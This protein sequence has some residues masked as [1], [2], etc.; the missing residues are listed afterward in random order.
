MPHFLSL[1]PPA[2]TL[3]S[4]LRSPSTALSLAARSLIASPS[5]LHS[6]FS[7]A[8]YASLASTHRSC[9]SLTFPAIGPAALE[10]SEY[11]FGRADAGVE[12]SSRVPSGAGASRGGTNT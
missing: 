10:N 11:V 3:P 6:L 7:N 12:A 8:S 2:F 9:T 1:I 5:L 4:P